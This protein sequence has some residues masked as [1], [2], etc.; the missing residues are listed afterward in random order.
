MDVKDKTPGADAHRYHKPHAYQFLQ[1]D[2]DVLTCRGHCGLLKHTHHTFIQS[3]NLCAFVCRLDIELSANTIQLPLL[4]GATLLM[5][6]EGWVSAQKNGPRL[7]RCR[8]NSCAFTNWL[9]N[10]RQDRLTAFQKHSVAHRAFWGTNKSSDFKE[11]EIVTSFHRDKWQQ[12]KL[13]DAEQLKCSSPPSATYVR[14]CLLLLK[15]KMQSFS[16]TIFYFVGYLWI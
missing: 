3:L 1:N 16:I 7:R 14:W 6:S 9:C 2:L 12:L 11:A 4:Y 13:L 15:V 5:G 10:L 8:L